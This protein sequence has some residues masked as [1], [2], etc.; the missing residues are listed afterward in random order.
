MIKNMEVIVT[1]LELRGNGTVENP[2]R[3]IYQVYDK[4]GNLLAEDDPNH[5]EFTSHDMLNFSQWCFE[6]DKDRNLMSLNDWKVR[7]K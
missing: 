3:R 1:D 7:Y 6:N 5:P 4:E 2:Y